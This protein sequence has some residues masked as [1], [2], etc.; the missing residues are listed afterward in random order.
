GRLGLCFSKPGHVRRTM[1]R[2]IRRGDDSRAQA[3]RPCGIIRAADRVPL[4]SRGGALRHRYCLQRLRDEK[5]HAALARTV[6]ER[7]ADADFGTCRH[8]ANKAVDCRWCKTLA[9]DS[10]PTILTC[11][12]SALK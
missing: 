4:R 9:A 10:H 11:T 1:D 2:P 3:E 5:R 12:V 8:C 6:A 7:V